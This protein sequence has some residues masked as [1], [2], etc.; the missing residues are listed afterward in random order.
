MGEGE[1]VQVSIGESEGV[2]M[3]VWLCEGE[4]EDEG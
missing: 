4:D 3:R 1:G 2:R